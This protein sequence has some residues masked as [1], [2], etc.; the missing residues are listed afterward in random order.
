MQI[1]EIKKRDHA[2]DQIETHL[3][4]FTFTCEFFRK[5]MKSTKSLKSHIIYNHTMKEEDIEAVE[6][7]APEPF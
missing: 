4:Q 2:T 6:L 7:V 5:L 3:D 1:K